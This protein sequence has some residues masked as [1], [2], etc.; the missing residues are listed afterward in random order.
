MLSKGCIGS[1]SRLGDLD[2]LIDAASQ[3]AVAQPSLLQK[4]MGS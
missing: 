1:P 3:S 2:A 4:H